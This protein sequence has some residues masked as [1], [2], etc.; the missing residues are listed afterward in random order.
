MN[1]QRSSRV[2]AGVDF[3]PGHFSGFD[4]CADIKSVTLEL[5]MCIICVSSLI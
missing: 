5:F 2:V 4:C 1:S 3:M